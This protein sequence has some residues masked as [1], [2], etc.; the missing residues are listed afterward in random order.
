M[1]KVIIA[2]DHPPAR[3]GL[4]RVLNEKPDIQVVGEAGT[5]PELEAALRRV[6]DVLL[7]DIRM[8][9]F[10]AIRQVPELQ[11]RFPQMKIVIM[12]AYKNEFYAQKLIPQVDGY[13][14]KIERLEAF[15]AAV[16]EVG[17]GGK[18]FTNP[19]LDLAFNSP[20]VPKLSDREG[21]VLRLVALGLTTA[22]IAPELFIST[23]TVESHIQEV[24]HK[25]G[26]RGRTAAVVKALELGL[27]SISLADGT[28]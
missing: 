13:V 14:L 19:V 28:R 18:H 3:E 1:I 10:D 15:A 16:Q 25:L 17:R 20:Q 24:C 6:P 12:T 7:L 26:V 27:I 21:E 2:D 5:G 22:E 23:R 8:P 9:E 4:K 11:A